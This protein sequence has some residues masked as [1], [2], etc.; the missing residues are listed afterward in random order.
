MLRE[1]FFQSS[2]DALN[3]IQA[4]SSSKHLVF[5]RMVFSGMLRRVALI[6]T[7]ASQELSASFIN[8]T[9]SVN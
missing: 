3:E 8:V 9:K 5:R 1:E 7:N 6:R 4:L 2:V